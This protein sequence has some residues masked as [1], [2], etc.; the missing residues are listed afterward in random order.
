MFGNTTDAIEYSIPIFDQWGK[1]WMANTWHL[2]R[3]RLVNGQEITF[4]Y[5]HA[6]S[7]VNG[8]QVRSEWIS[9]M[10]LSLFLKS[11]SSDGGSGFLSLPCEPPSLLQE[12]PW[13]SYGRYNG[14][15]IAPVY[16][17][18]IEGL[19]EKIVFNRS[20]SSELR[21]GQSIYE[22]VWFIWTTSMS[23]PR[24]LFPFLS[25][26]DESSYVWGYDNYPQVL[27][28]LQWRKLDNFQ[29]FNKVTNTP[30][31]QVD[32]TYNNQATERLT[33]LSVQQ[34]GSGLAIP[35]YRFS[36]NTS[37]ALPGY[38]ADHTDHW[39]FYNGNKSYDYRMYKDPAALRAYYAYRQPDVN[40]LQSGILSR[41]VYPTGS[42]TDFQFESHTYAKEVDVVRNTPLIT[43]PDNPIA[44]GLRVKKIT[45]Y[46][47]GTTQT[48]LEK[49]YY[50]V[51]NYNPAVNPA[52]LPSS[53]VLGGQAKYYWDD[54]EVYAQ[55]SND[56]KYKQKIFSSHTLL[57]TSS[58]SQ[59][60]HIG[61]TEVV[62]KRADGSYTIFKYTNFDNGHLDEPLPA[63][64][65]LQP[66]RTI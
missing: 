30:I 45:H 42:R 36:Y 33:L 20:T 48:P 41:I 24:K 14:Q 22:R 54:Y 28:K 4:T 65:L 1:D 32:F 51:A 35:P 29:V 47:S 15:L 63:G 6:K 40:Y 52:T 58:N 23:A 66:I 46:E 19:N 43:R 2:T 11:G 38:L 12:G 60:S 39:G 50:Y 59:G 8:Q 53:G 37:V 27:N 18:S 13:D 62:E 25:D 7:T 17:E 49:T 21:Y 16:L 61:Y 5:G 44:G 64:S 26:Y 31:N 56:L 34:K 55:G 57:P 3:I 10:Y 9:S